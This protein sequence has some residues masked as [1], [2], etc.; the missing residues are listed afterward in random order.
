MLKIGFRDV[1][2]NTEARK[3]VVD[4]THEVSRAVTESGITDG[5][6]VL[7]SMHSTSAIIINENEGGLIN[8]II[9]KVKEDY[10]SG[11]GWEHNMIDNN[12]DG[13]L[14]G[15]FIGPSITIPVR[16]GSPVLGTWQSV[17][18]LELDGPRSGRRVVIEVIGK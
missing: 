16:G 13:H 3:E 7:H 14:A 11:K 8:D 10:P 12:A 18:F 6:C 5:I 17:F 9:T 1:R 4:I 2:I 15:A